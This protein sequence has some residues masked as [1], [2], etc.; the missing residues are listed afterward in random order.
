MAVRAKNG[1]AKAFEELCALFNRKIFYFIFKKIQNREDAEDI[2]QEVLIKSYKGLNSLR[3][4]E[5]NFSAWLFKITN[6]TIN[7][8]FRKKYRSPEVSSI[9]ENFDFPDIR[10]LYNSILIKS[11]LEEAHENFKQL[12][13]LYR[14]VLEMRFF[15]QLSVSETAAALNKSGSAIKMLQYRARKELKSV[16]KKLP[17][18]T[19]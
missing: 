12:P 2:L 11:D 14:Y 1:D 10:S 3:P 6:N 5:I 13:E 4:G 8:Y 18:Y 19:Q 9:D 17:L 7:D 16:S 15:W